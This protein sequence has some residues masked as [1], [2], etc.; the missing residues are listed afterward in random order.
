MAPPPS[1]HPE[2]PPAPPP[3][4]PSAPPLHHATVIFML[5][6]GNINILWYFRFAFHVPSTNIPPTQGFYEWDRSCGVKPLSRPTW[7]TGHG[8][9]WRWFFLEHPVRNLESFLYQTVTLYA[10]VYKLLRIN[11]TMSYKSRGK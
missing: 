10:L 3:A 6:L 9:G 7:C 11:F 8:Q 5:C 4:P 1:P 2:P